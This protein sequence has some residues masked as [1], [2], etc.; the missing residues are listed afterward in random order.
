MR[1]LK[2]SDGPIRKVYFGIRSR[3]LGMLT[4]VIIVII[5]IFT[6][7]LF[8]LQTSQL[9]K[10]MEIKAETL[11]KIL[12]NPAEFYLDN[13]I[14]TSSEEIK[15]KFE[16]IKKEALSFKSYNEDIIK[17][18]LTDEKGNVRFSTF[19]YDYKRKDI[20][21]YIS[22]GLEQD[23]DT[24]SQEKYKDPVVGSKEKEY[25]NNYAFTIPIFLKSGITVSI[26]ND[27]NTSY[28]K[29][30]NPETTDAQKRSIYSGLY[31]KYKDILGD[32][33]DV[34]FKPAAD[35]TSKTASTTLQVK[36]SGDIDFLFMR[37]FGELMKTREKRIAKDKKNLWN[38]A[39]LEKKKNEKFSFYE[40]DRP[41]NAKEVNDEII[42]NLTEFANTVEA[43]R[44]LGAI[45]IIFNEDMRQQH[46][47]Q[48]FGTI[49]IIALCTILFSV[50]IFLILLNYMIRNLKLLENWAVSVSKG[51]L[52]TKIKIESNDEIGRL[53]D[54]FN[55][56]LDEIIVK[57]KLERFVPAS[58]MHMIKKNGDNSILLGATNRKNL[59]FMFSDVRGF[60]S[61]SEKNDPETVI[62]ILNYYLELQSDIIH[63]TTGDINDYVGDE[64]MAHFSDPRK[65]DTAI[66]TA[67]KI[68]TAIKKTNQERTAEGKPVF[69]V[70][71]GLHCGDVVTGN[72]GSKQ[73]MDFACVGDA[74]NMTSRLC[75]AAEPGQIII[76]LDMFKKAKGKYKAKRIDDLQLKGKKDKIEAVS[77]II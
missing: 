44:R 62:E 33:Y 41:A 75:H 40:K 22:K 23:E 24:I 26:I 72:V 34:N 5:S 42:S 1:F 68:M 29:Y 76:S 6:L 16:F 35:K 9:K 39:W 19:D 74:V 46:R 10:E 50:V 37:L 55:H 59:V 67:V 13:D 48:N 49:A 56:M 31:A 58:A 53:G 15:M 51:N 70:G 52:D 57:Y 17:I 7:I 11:T 65:I 21:F 69:E 43:T 38:N 63:K 2:Q 14:E 73:R 20:P 3:F 8:F 18:I 71:I 30:H 64:I 54:V 66:R 36:K 28:L 47:L 27:F 77:I 12:L 4:I 45:S 60:T 25:R 61:F 32:E